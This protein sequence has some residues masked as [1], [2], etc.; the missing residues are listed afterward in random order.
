MVQNEDHPD[1]VEKDTVRDIRT[2]KDQPVHRPDDESVVVVHA[3]G[4]EL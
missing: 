1:R 4:I 2:L 3:E